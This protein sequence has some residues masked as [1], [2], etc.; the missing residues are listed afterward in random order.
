MQ[1]ATNNADIGLLIITIAI[2][3]NQISKHLSTD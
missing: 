2:D 1:V 3:Q